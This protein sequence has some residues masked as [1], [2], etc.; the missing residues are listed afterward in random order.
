MN[1]AQPAP[2]VEEEYIEPEYQ[3]PNPLLEFHELVDKVHMHHGNPSTMYRHIMNGT[4]KEYYS[5]VLDEIIY[6]LTIMPIAR[7][8]HGHDSDEDQ[9]T[10]TAGFRRITEA[11]GI[12]FN[13]DSGAIFKELVRRM[14]DYPIDDAREAYSLR[15]H[16]KLH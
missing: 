13:K 4:I 8:L 6:D 11:L 14:D 16:N 12:V 3:V 7:N 2:A 9:Q 1:K 10:V 5:V 15:Y